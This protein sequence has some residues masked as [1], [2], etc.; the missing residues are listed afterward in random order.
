MKNLII[1]T[2]VL[3]LTHLNAGLAQNP[4]AEGNRLILSVGTYGVDDAV[5]VP[6]LQIEAVFALSL[7][8]MQPTVG[9]FATPTGTYYFYAGWTRLQIIANRLLIQPSIATG[10]Y[11]FGS[12]RYLGGTIQFRSGLK[13]GY[14][15]SEAQF[16]A[17][18]IFH[19]SNAG[20]YDSNPGEESVLVSYLF[21]F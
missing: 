19:T 1:A 9:F 8:Y 4:D 14:K 15:L 7:F 3:F 5:P 10:L 16:M 6:E 18:G 17:V 20:I 21:R 11:H 2:A 12:G 13:I